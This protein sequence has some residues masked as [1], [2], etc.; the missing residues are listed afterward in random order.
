[1]SLAK[2]GALEALPRFGWRG[3]VA[4]FRTDK[5]HSVILGGSMVMLVGSAVVS[6]FNFGYNVAAARMLGP[7]GF[8]HASAAVT[9][10]MLVSAIT[11]SF[12]LVCAKFVARN[13]TAAGKQRVY[14]ALHRKAWFVGLL[15]A[16]SLAAASQPIAH[17]LN[18]PSAAIV[19][20]LAAGIAF[21]VPLG[22]TRGRMQG[23][24]SFRPLSGNFVLEAVIRFGGALAL[25]WAGYGVLGAVGAI[26]ASVAIA[27]LLPSPRSRKEPQP[28]DATFVPASFREGMQ[29]IVFFVGQVI[30]NNIDI[31]LVKHFFSP[32]RAGLYAAVALV[33]RVVYFSSWQVASA[34]FP[35]AAGNKEKDDLS[36]LV[37]P[38]LLV[39][40]IA[41]G[42][43]VLLGTFS[44]AIVTFVFG[45]RYGEA[46][47]LLSLYAA[48]TGCYA[49][50]VVLMTF[51]MSRKIANT[52][53]LQMAFSGALVIGITAFHATLQQV[54][55]VQVV[56]MV[57]LLAAVS[58]PFFRIG[59]EMIRRDVLRRAA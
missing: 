26:T 48:S 50:S 30:I 29:A 23:T 39:V 7:E 59:R 37:V 4:H 5:S 55:V 34:M 53:W 57:L 9:L 18:L 20:L 46:E 45:G 21:Y 43:V 31:L 10:L 44:H 28:A 49:L 2:P 52:A 27:Y 3:A 40:A 12:Q 11:L 8:G 36:V 47:P 15:L 6:A 24:C 42:A 56:L 19:I 51:E 17:Y 35:I 22:A 25:M 41:V 14:R 16:V 1:M 54:I 33:G 58:Y 32:E 13:E 38:L